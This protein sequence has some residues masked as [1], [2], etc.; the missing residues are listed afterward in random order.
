[1]ECRTEISDKDLPE[2]I[3]NHE[4]IH[5]RQQLELLILPFYLWYFAEFLIQFIK[6][7][8]RKEAYLNISFEREA[9]R[10]QFDLEYLKKRKRFG[11]MG[12]V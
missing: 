11:F 3:L 5:L 1:M 6:L 7:R 2:Y 8:N 4:K 10:N 9:Y 12:F